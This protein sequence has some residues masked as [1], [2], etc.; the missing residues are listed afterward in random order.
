MKLLLLVV[1]FF[2]AVSFAA[3]GD[4]MEHCFTEDTCFIQ[5][6][7]EDGSVF[8]TTQ[9][10]PKK[11]YG[12]DALMMSLP[13]EDYESLTHTITHKIQYHIQKEKGSFRPKNFVTLSDLRATTNPQQAAETFVKQITSVGNYCGKV[14]IINY[15]GVKQSFRFTP[16]TFYMAH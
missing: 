5:V 11:L 6:A 14:K 10:K 3:I 2:S 9:K 12:T 4:I 7:L 13:L 8:Y 15:K 1:W 16:K